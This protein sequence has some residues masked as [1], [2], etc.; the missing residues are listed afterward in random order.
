MTETFEGTNG[1][2]LVGKDWIVPAA[3][4]PLSVAWA[5]TGQWGYAASWSAL[6][7]TAAAIMW[8]R[9]AKGRTG[10]TPYRAGPAIRKPHEGRHV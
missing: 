10:E 7:V 1:F 5:Q 3:A 4:L 9:V 8:W 2:A 6:M